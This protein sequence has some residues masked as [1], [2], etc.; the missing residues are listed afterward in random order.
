MKTLKKCPFCGAYPSM[1]YQYT[2]GD[3]KNPSPYNVICGNCGAEIAW[4]ETEEEA[5]EAWNTR[6]EP[7]F[8]GS[9]PF[10][11]ERL[12]NGNTNTR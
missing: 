5:V 1:M 4:Y 10:G 12:K 7:P 3:Y 8:N 11:N 9:V 6:Y 2:I